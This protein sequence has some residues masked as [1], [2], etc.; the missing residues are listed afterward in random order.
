MSRME[1]QP[2][3]AIGVVAL[4]LAGGVGFVLA[5]YRQTGVR[6]QPGEP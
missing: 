3:A 1:T 6:L 2:L 4:L 5:L